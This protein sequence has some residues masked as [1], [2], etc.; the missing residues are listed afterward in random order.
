MNV[1]GRLYVHNLREHSLL[2][3]R[4][5]IAYIVHILHNSIMHVRA[6]PLSLCQTRLEA[7]HCSQKSP[8]VRPLLQGCSDKS[9]PQ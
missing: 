4:Q 9:P 1:T 3:G 5:Y 2:A 7:L 6:L 8:E